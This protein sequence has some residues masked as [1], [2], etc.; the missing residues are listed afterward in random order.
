MGASHPAIR[1]LGRLCIASAALGA[2]VIF[3]VALVVAYSV[4]MRSLGLGGLRGDFE[5]V[6]LACAT[7]AS[8]FLPLCQLRK[9]HVM[10]D[11]FTSRM[12]ERGQMRLDGLWTLIFAI[13]W[14]VLCWRLVQGLVEMNAYGDR[15]MLLHVPLWMLYVP[16]VFGTFL[17]CVVAL[18]IGV[19][20]L[21]GNR[22]LAGM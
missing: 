6:E 20:L 12:P 4:T 17:S 16:A 18:V 19:T 2:L 11:L 9:G 14:A 13:A 10:V 15:T 3:L 5:I 21:R 1:W 22:V 8:L 7:C